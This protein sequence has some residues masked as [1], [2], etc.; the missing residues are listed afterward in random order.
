MV[1]VDSMPLCTA[2]KRGFMKFCKTI[3][4]LYKAP[5]LKTREKMFDEKYNHLKEKMFKRLAV[6]KNITITTDLWTETMNVKSFM[7]VTVHYIE[8][9][10]VCFIVL[11][12]LLLY[13]L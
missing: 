13:T 3:Q 6:A 7:G 4:P 8:G 11:T 2:E 9:M 5:A 10:L 1:A 12:A